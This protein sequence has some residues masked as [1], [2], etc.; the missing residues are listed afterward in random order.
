MRRTSP[1]TRSRSS[2]R[3]FRPRSATSPWFRWWSAKRPPDEVAEVLARLWGGPETLLVISSDLSHYEPYARA[4]QHDAATAAAIER[5]DG[6]ALGPARRL[7]LPADLR[8]ARSR[9]S[10]A[11][12]GPCAWTFAT[13]A[14]P[15]AR[16][17][18]WSATAPGRS[19]RSGTDPCPFVCSP[20][21][22]AS[23][24]SPGRARSIRSICRMPRCS[25][26]TP[27]ACRRSRSTTP[28]TACPRPSCSRTGRPRRRT[29]SA[30][31]S[32]PRAGSPTC[33]A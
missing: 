9:R 13:R 20:A 7:R 3:S 17:T 14:T 31:C 29:A 10:G 22:A 24:T 18:R 27:S 23:A 15:R 4:R 30:S 8:P 5:L 2:C 32:R 19:Q 33:S 11:G 26:T 1:S 21:P 6:A 16:R 25:P 12:S 28:S